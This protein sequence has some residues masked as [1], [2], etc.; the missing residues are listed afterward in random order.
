MA[1]SGTTTAPR[2]SSPLP[3]LPLR[4]IACLIPVCL[5]VVWS[6]GNWPV[7]VAG[8]GQLR[9]AD[10]LWLLAAVVITCLC[11]VAVCFA[12]QGTVLEPLPP[13]RL[14]ATQFA[15][16]AANDLLP[17]GIGAH[18]VTLRFYRRC[19]V[20][21]TRA[22]ASLALYSLA[23]PLARLVLLLVLLSLTPGVLHLG[24]AVP[25]G[26]TLLM[27]LLAL[28]AAALLVLV[29]LAVRP[30]RGAVR[31]FLGA[32]LTDA[33]A[34]HI[35]PARVA[36]LWGGALAFPALQ[37]GVLVTV[38]LALR[39]PAPW[40]HVGIAYLAAAAAVGFIPAPGGLGSVDAALL[41]TLTAIGTPVTTATAVVIGFRAITSWLPLLPGVLALYALVRRK[42]L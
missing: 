25:A 31:G 40:L 41:V 15:A 16:G 30:L 3:R 35:R 42:V 27:T 22:S 29:L 14:L 19:G 5:V 11:W 6:I 4:Q 32:A 17:A 24:E 23:L 18:L 13:G 39:A 34:L 12:R 21:L 20:P 8:L 2:R 36:A 33:R 37:A 1:L 38:A 9:A 26:R 10:R 7:I 28:T